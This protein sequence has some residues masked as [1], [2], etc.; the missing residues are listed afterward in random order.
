M[1]PA[2]DF[3]L[4][5]VIALVW[6]GNFLAAA[7]AL[8]HFPALFFTTLRLSAVLLLLLPFLRPIPKPQRSRFIIAA[9]C[10][11]ALHFGFNFWAIALAGDISSVAIALQS[12]IPMSA[13]LAWWM[14]GERIDARAGSGIAVAFVGVAVLGFDPLVLDAPLALLMSLLAAVALAFG[15]VLLRRLGG[16]HTFQ[17]Q[18]WTAVVGVP[19]LLLL[20]LWTE[21]VSWPLLATAS[22]LEWGGVLYSAIGASL[23]GH[24]LL[25]VLLQRHPVARVMPF[26]LLTPV[27][28]VALGVLYWGDRPG[29]RLLVGGALVLAGVLAVSLRRPSLK[30]GRIEAPKGF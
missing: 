29:P 2:R 20:S 17:V 10:N 1:L 28:A 3:L 25:Y 26:L 22:A 16:L 27:F 18:A 9:L 11:G 12:Y 4:V 14:L 5:V 6:A 7:A 13:L 15:T 30:S 24:G 19:P 23:I 21:P 8:R